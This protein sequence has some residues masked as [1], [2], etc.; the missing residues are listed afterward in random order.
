[1]EFIE[2]LLDFFDKPIS[3]IEK[4][5]GLSNGYI[6]KYATKRIADPT[7]LR[8][9]LKKAGLNPDYFITGAGKPDSLYKINYGGLCTGEASFRYGA[10]DDTKI[11]FLD[12][13]ASAGSGKEISSGE[14]ARYIAIPDSVAHIKGLTALTVRGDS[15]YPTLA[16]G[17]IVICD[18]AG[19]SGDGIYVIRTSESLF[20][21]RVVLTP[22]G[23]QVI[24]DNALY[25]AYACKTEDAEMIGRVRCAVVRKV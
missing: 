5:L 4:E 23:Y 16:D 3:A 24:S 13:Q 21:K 19:W 12:A 25:P 9:A 18:S 17:D 6:N 1:M 14:V 7:K 11:P 20:V 8:H 2:R 10:S 22:A 15:M